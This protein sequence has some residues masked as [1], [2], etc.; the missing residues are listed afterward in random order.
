MWGEK[1]MRVELGQPTFLTCRILGKNSVRRELSCILDPNFHYS[2]IYAKEALAL[3]YSDASFRPE[4][5][6]SLKHPEEVPYVLT[7]RGIERSIRVRL[8]EVALGQLV[9]R[10]VDALVFVVDIPLL[11]PA[12]VILGRTFLQN[13]KLGYNFKEKTIE[14]DYA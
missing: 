2:A 11:L 13:F 5:L 6:A 7:F 3:G 4:E 12:D 14:L 9:A 10:D 8:K 1:K